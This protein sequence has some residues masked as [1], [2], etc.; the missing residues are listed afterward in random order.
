[1]DPWTTPRSEAATGLRILARLIA[2]LH[3]S[4]HTGGETEER[5]SDDQSRENDNE[6][7]SVSPSDGPSIG[8]H[9]LTTHADKGRDGGLSNDVK[10]WPAKK[11]TGGDDESD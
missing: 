2:R 4:Q 9:P 10:Q 3:M 5:E 11:H 7:A 1:M 8:P 6:S